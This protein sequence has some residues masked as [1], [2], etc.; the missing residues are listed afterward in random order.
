MSFGHAYYSTPE[1]RCQVVFQKNIV[2]NGHGVF[3][4]IAEAMRDR[5]RV[6]RG[7]CMVGGIHGIFSHGHVTGFSGPRYKNVR[8]LKMSDIQNSPNIQNLA[9]I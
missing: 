4:Q 6:A 7:Q 2:Q 5:G 3:V 8:H 9:K 1:A